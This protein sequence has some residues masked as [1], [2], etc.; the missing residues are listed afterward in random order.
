MRPTLALNQDQCANPLEKMISVI[1]PT[2]TKG[3]EHLCNLL[4]KVVQFDDKVESDFKKLPIQRDLIWASE[5]FNATQEIAGRHLERYEARL[6]SLTEEITNKEQE[7]RNDTTTLKNLS[8]EN[9][10]RQKEVNRLSNQLAETNRR[11]QKA[12]DNISHLQHEISKRKRRRVGLIFATI[13]SFGKKL[14]G[15]CLLIIT[16]STTTLLK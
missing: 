11:L 2:C 10:T 9:E 13:F 3:L 1:R 16:G 7:I 8:K 15:F 12:E 5:E 6:I 14:L 4:D